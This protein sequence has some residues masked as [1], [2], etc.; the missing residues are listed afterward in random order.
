ME[1]FEGKKFR[2]TGKQ[3]ITHNTYSNEI[4]YKDEFIP[5]SSYVK[6]LEQQ[7]LT[8]LEVEAKRLKTRLDYETKEYGECDQIEF[9]RYLSL[10][11]K[12]YSLSNKP[13]THF[14]KSGKSQPMKFEIVPQP[15]L[16]KPSS[17]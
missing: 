6:F 14:A 11:D 2:P 5:T 9:K 8:G 16:P 12:I 10:L 17:R 1:K 3:I 15:Y 4:E 13:K 7:Y